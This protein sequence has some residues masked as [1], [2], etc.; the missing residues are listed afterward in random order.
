MLESQQLKSG[1]VE[2]NKMAPN[3]YALTTS[4]QQRLLYHQKWE[5][6][7]RREFLSEVTDFLVENFR[8]IYKRKGGMF[9]QLNENTVLQ[10]ANKHQNISKLLQRD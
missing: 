1:F 9:Q 7:N 2:R 8:Q 10:V 6:P 5:N 3:I 4:Y